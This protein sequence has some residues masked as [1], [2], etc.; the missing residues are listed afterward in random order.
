MLWKSLAFG[1]P[2][3]I[4]Y[5]KG[6][7]YS[8]TGYVA[9]QSL[10]NPVMYHQCI[11]PELSLVCVSHRKR[12]DQT[13]GWILCKADGAYDGRLYEGCRLRQWYRDQEY[14]EFWEV[15]YQFIWYDSFGAG[16]QGTHEHWN[17]IVFPFVSEPG[18]NFA[19]EVS[20]YSKKKCL[21]VSWIRDRL[22]TERVIGLATIIWS[23]DCLR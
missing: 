7:G 20:G 5:T 15:S 8:K 12:C 23:D 4:L 19:F 17:C 16:F 21:S 10:R 11:S 22:Q 9:W 6:R 14:S 13:W 1:N 2:W 3:N 18:V